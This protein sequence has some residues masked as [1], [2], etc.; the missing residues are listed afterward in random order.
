MFYCR[1]LGGHRL[2]IQIES[3]GHFFRACSFGFLVNGFKKTLHKLLF[4]P[5]LHKLLQKRCTR[6]TVVLGHSAVM[7]ISAVIRPYFCSKIFKGYGYDCANKNLVLMF[8]SCVFF[9]NSNTSNNAWT[10]SIPTKVGLM[11]NMTTLYLRKFLCN[12]CWLR[13]LSEN[14]LKICVLLRVK[15]ILLH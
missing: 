2:L 10:G 6:I 5:F 8:F 15:S 3:P 14:C 12:F 13:L 7:G 9:R 1:C 4:C 11:T